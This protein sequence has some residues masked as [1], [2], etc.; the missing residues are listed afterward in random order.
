VRGYMSSHQP[1]TKKRAAAK[2]RFFAVVEELRTALADEVPGE[3]QKEVEKAV[4]AVRGKKR[5]DL[6]YN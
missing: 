1:N 3:M 4:G 6:R 5:R 2:R